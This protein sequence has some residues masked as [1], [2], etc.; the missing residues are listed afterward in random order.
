MS[1]FLLR[2]PVRVAVAFPAAIAMAQLYLAETAQSPVA[3]PRLRRLYRVYFEH[4]AG[5]EDLLAVS[6]EVGLALPERIQSPQSPTRILS[7]DP[8][9]TIL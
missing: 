8:T 6:Q 2:L 5:P 3:L 4:L 9:R 1:C 7:L